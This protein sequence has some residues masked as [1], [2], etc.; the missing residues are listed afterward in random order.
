MATRLTVFYSWQSDTPPNLNRSFIEKALLEALKRLHSDATLE[1][2]LRDATVELDKDTKGV[3][4]SPLWT[5]ARTCMKT[6]G[7]KMQGF[8]ARL[9]LPAA[10]VPGWR[11][12]SQEAHDKLLAQI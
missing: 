10:A 2:A 5:A 7:L 3:A 8:L 1:N 12:P 4:G 6:A 11:S 9:W